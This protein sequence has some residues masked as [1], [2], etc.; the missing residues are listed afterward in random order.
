MVAG[1]SGLS[2][3]AA[4]VSLLCFAVGS[5]GGGLLGRRQGGNRGRWV[6]GAF[7]GEA[8]LVVAATL[9]AVGVGVGEAN[10]RRELVIGLLALA[11]GFGWECPT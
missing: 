10:A 11:M 3:S 5:A 7:F 6:T 8:A 9:A 1:A 4:L 2:A